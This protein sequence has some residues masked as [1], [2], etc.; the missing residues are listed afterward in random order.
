M[1]RIEVIVLLFVGFFVCL[2]IRVCSHSKFQIVHRCG[3]CLS[4][5]LDRGDQ[6]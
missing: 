2:H 5:G 1:K 6:R 4:S 3:A